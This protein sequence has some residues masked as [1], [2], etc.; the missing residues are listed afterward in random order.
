MLSQYR[1]VPLN[2]LIH[3]QTQITIYLPNGETKENRR[4]NETRT[5]RV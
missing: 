5:L 1:D 4:V 2:C 3:I